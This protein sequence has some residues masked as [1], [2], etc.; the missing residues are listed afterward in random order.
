MSREREVTRP[1]D[2]ARGRRLEPAAVGWTRTPLHRTAISGWGR[3][4]RWEYWGS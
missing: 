4:K 3:T 2:L 1:T